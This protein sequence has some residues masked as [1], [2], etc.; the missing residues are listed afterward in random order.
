M[1]SKLPRALRENGGDSCVLSKGLLRDVG[2]TQILGVSMK[3]NVKSAEAFYEKVLGVIP[4]MIQRK[5]SVFEIERYLRQ[6]VKLIEA[7]RVEWQE[8]EGL[9][10]K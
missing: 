6:V 3:I 10:N 2:Y 4:G 7:D 1:P 8:Y 5:E 9:E